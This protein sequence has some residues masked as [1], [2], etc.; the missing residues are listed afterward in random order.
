M[1]CPKISLSDTTGC[2]VLRRNAG[3][4]RSRRW[5]FSQWPI[6]QRVAALCMI[7]LLAVPLGCRHTRDVGHARRGVYHTVKRHQTFWRICKTYGV[8]MEEVARVNGIR[9]K[10]KIEVGQRIF[11]PG[12]KRVLKVD[13][14]LEDVTAGGKAAAVTYE[15]GRFIWPVEGQVTASFWA[16]ETAA[17]RRHDGIDISAMTGTVVRAAD[18][19]KVVYSDN[20]MR[21]YGNLIIIEHQDHFFTIYAHNEENLVKEE[22]LV[23]QGDAIA[24][25]GKT[26][27][28]TGPHLHF[29]IRKGSE[30]LDPM[31][32]LP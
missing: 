28:A 5:L 9:D 18:S 32:F 6:G 31:Q 1:H 11:I 10:T 4:S 13:I 26:G 16:K 14:Y 22:V 25:V 20:K 8:D 30:P 7:F 24:K 12:V 3:R 21:G 27:S 23:K 2:H 15:K 19:G 17:K 29:E